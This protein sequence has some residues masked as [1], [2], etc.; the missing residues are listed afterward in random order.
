MFKT[1]EKRLDEIALYELVAEELENGQQSKGLWAKA[2]AEGEGNLEKASG[3]YIKLRVQMVEDQWVENERLQQKI[4]RREQEVQDS[5]SAEI[6]TTDWVQKGQYD[7]R[8]WT[9]FF[10][11]VVLIIVLTVLFL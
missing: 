8:F 1:P 2:L 11:I 9:G 3:L 4:S 6:Q 5:R 7:E 10:V